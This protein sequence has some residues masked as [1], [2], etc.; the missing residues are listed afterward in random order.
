MKI[1]L[2]SPDGYMESV[3][4]GKCAKDEEGVRQIVEGY[5]SEFFLGRVRNVQVDLH[6][7]TVTFEEGWDRDG[8]VN[9]WEEHT[10]ELIS[11]DVIGAVGAGAGQRAG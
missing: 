9:S 8:E 10:Y 6:S 5:Q 11:F 7:G 2:V 1:Y 4:G 3:I